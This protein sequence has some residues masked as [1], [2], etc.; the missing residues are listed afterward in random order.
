M[1]FGP[2]NKFEA[3]QPI[4][5]DEAMNDTPKNAFDTFE[6]RM[7][8]RVADG[9][10][11]QEE[12]NKLLEKAQERRDAAE[13]RAV[14]ETRNA[15]DM[16][17]YNAWSNMTQEDFDERREAQGL[18]NEGYESVSIMRSYPRLKGES[19]AD[20]GKRLHQIKAAERA[21]EIE[22]L[23]NHPEKTENNAIRAY[24][25]MEIGRAHV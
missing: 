18:G 8:E 25:E 24:R 6:Q 5:T 9:T 23:E 4:S 1:E 17:A 16:E 19:P 22:Y 20:Y 2:K 21:V 7:Q 3:G 12:A 15:A 11:T 14:E 13:K 10:Y